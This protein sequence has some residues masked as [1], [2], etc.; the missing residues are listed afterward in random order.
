MHLI[1]QGIELLGIGLTQKA[2]R[3]GRWHF[4]TVAIFKRRLWRKF[5]FHMLW[6]ITITVPK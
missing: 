6:T 1:V 4:D 3:R 5:C 2:L